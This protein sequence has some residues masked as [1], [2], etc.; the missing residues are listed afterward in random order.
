MDEIET[1]QALH[2]IM[3]CVMKEQY[4][5]ALVSIVE[6]LASLHERITELQLSE[7]E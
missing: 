7:E 6:V 5:N 3:D 2:R 4:S 1:K